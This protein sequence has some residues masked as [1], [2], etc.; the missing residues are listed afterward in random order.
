MTNSSI[1]LMKQFTDENAGLIT[2][3]FFFNI[4]TLVLETIAISILLSKIFTSFNEKKSPDVIKKLLIYFLIIFI[5]IRLC[6][7]IRSMIYNAIIPK[8]F[9]FLRTRIYESILNRYQIDYSELNIGHILYNFEHIPASFRKVMMGLLQEYI[10]NFLALLICIGYLFYT[11]VKIGSIIIVGIIIFIAVI[12]LTINQNIE[13][14]KKEH[15]V[16]IKDNQHIQDRLS[17]LFDIY[18]SGTEEEEINEFKQMEQDLKK[19]MF[20]YSTNVTGVISGIEVVV[21]AMLAATLIV[22]FKSY[23][24][25]QMSNELIVSTIL[26][27]TYFFTYF[28]KVAHNYIGISDVFGYS[29]ESDDFL[30]EINALGKKSENIQQSHKNQIHNIEENFNNDIFYGPIRLK[31]IH[32]K[33]NTKEILNDLNLY[34]EPSTKVAIYGKSGSGKSTIA[35][36]LLGFY[37]ITSGNITFGGI[38]INNINTDKIR[39]NIGVVNQNIKLF[40]KTIYE[41]IIYGINNQYTKDDIYKIIY[42]ILGDSNIFDNNTNYLDNSV[43]ISGSKLSGGQKQVINIIRALLKDCPIL[44]LDEP[45]SALDQNTKSVIF[46][47]IQNIKDKTIIII[48]HDKDILSYIDK[49]Y[50]MINGKLKNM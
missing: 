5:G 45:T 2:S 42:N 29:K 35:K 7:F 30:N 32:F 20:T 14:S 47:I 16:F 50:E 3:Y 49:S 9:Y 12:L 18:T 13:L 38:N 28:S 21:I 23:Q 24:N 11:N 17:N 34:I 31:N 15:D 33:Y 22:I 4:I 8:F 46:K 10:P 41:N 27:L 1:D 43:G 39:K 48:T 40:D 36:L 37:N 19:T 44:I 26:I 6:Y 25:K